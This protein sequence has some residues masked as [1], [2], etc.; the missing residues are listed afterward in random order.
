MN[1]YNIILAS[2]SPRRKAFFEQMGIP[3]TQKVY[4]VN[5]VFPDSLSGEAIVEYLVKLK[6]EPFK[7]SIE[8]DQLVIT[9]DT[10]VWHQNQ[11]LGKPQ[12]EKEAEQILRQLSNSTH[13][14]ITGVGFLQKDKWESLSCVSEVHFSNLSSAAIRDYIATGSPMDKAGAYGIQD[15]FGMLHIDSIKGSYTNIIGLPVSQV[16]KKLEEILEIKESF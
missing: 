16:L 10:I 5:E 11:C 13:Q 7:S 8:K 12:D 14:V 6:A 9:A 1:G 4:P 3:F 2:G 15:P